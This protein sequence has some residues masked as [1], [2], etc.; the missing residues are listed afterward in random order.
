MPNEPD[1]P[2]SPVEA[3]VASRLRHVAYEAA[4]LDWPFRASDVIDAV[5]TRQRTRHPHRT[6]WRQARSGRAAGAVLVAAV[7]V[8]VFF[9]P[10]PHVSLFKRLVTTSTPTSVP[11]TLPSTVPASSTTIASAP[12][13]IRLVLDRT[14]LTAGTA[15][16]GEALLTNT[17]GNS[18]TVNTCAA[19]GWLWV[20]LTNEKVGYNP[21]NPLI[22]CRPTVRLSPGLN[23]FSISISTDFQGCTRTTSEATP[24][25]PSCTPK[26]DLPP[27]PSG[28]YF[29]K[30]VTA[31]LPK[32]TRLL[33]AI[34]VTLLPA[35]STGASSCRARQIALG[36]GPSISPASGEHAFV[37][38]FTN[39]GTAPCTLDGYPRVRLLTSSGADLHMP[40]VGHSQYTTTAGPR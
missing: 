2:L 24:Q 4:D 12:V 15:I 14:R 26:G 8:A 10:L 32:G 37:V 36:N 28:L 27:L 40:Q 21:A 25:L 39:R 13:E 29:T 22:L 30:I 23:R 31:G 6:S 19:N 1:G 16:H 3:E 38:T 34:K 7:I 18:I 20:G 5:P 33:S 35:S 17:T 9:V 11:G